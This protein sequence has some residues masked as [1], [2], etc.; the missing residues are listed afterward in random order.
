MSGTRKEVAARKQGRI[1][2]A[3]VLVFVSENPEYLPTIENYGD[4]TV[5]EDIY[6]VRVDLWHTAS[7]LKRYKKLAAERKVPA[8]S[9]AQLVSLVRATTQKKYRERDSPP[10]GAG[11]LC[12]AILKGNNKTLWV[13]ETRGASCSWSQLQ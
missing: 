7:K 6:R 12:G 9:E 4:Y 5:E 10:F 13:S 3:V 11:P 1:A 2:P 8:I